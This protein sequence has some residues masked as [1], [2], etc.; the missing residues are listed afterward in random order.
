[1]SEQRPRYP[2]YRDSGIQWLGEIPAHWARLRCRFLFREVDARSE[3][4]QE[5]HLSMTQTRGLIPSKDLKTKRLQSESYAGGKL[6]QAN[7]LVLNRLKAHLGVFA[8]APQDG[9]VSP[10]YTVFRPK[11]KTRTRYYEHLFKTNAYVGELR[12]RT[13]GIVEGFWRLYTGSFYDIPAIYPPPT[14]QE[15]ILQF[16]AHTDRQVA[17]LIRGKRRLIELLNEQ[18]QTIIHRAV[19]RGLDPDVPLK[20][21]DIDWVG[22]VPVHWDV[23]PLKYWAYINQ[24]SLKEGTPEDSRFKYVDIGTVGT[25]GLVRAPEEVIFS[26]AP[27]RARRI[28]RQYDTILST[29]R[30]YLRAV[31]FFRDEVSNVIASTG[32]AVLTPRPGVHPEFLSLVIQ[33]NAFIDRVTANSVGIAYPA[34]AE[35]VLGAFHIPMPPD[36]TEQE[37]IVKSIEHE[38]VPV[39]AALRKVERE[40]KLIQEYRDRLVSDVVTGQIDVRGWQPPADEPVDDSETAEAFAEAEEG[41]EIEEANG[42]DQHE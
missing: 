38:L 26:N 5:T 17:K 22:D 21:S 32:F 4:G 31:Y 1:M 3:H 11:P 12:R 35:T 34:I 8:Y 39:D 15:S 13:K 10:D 9:V 41:E 25:R 16:I 29:V 6:C 42:D 23:R 18:K 28:V 19:T 20:P 37:A 40:V 30:T 7:D 14:E 33:G 27:S 2:E 24:Q 36:I